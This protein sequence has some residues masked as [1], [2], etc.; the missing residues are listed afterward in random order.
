MSAP[1]V[2]SLLAAVATCYLIEAEHYGPAAYFALLAVIW[3]GAGI[4]RAIKETQP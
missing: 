1:F 4:Q 2:V 3:T